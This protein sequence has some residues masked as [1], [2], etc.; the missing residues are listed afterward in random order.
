MFSFILNYEWICI[1]TN[2]HVQLNTFWKY[3][4][5]YI[6]LKNELKKEKQNLI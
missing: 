3:T 2:N 1:H 4:W 6:V 5:Q